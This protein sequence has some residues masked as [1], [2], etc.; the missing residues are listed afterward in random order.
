MKSKL[1][2]LLMVALF[3]LGT[4]TV[5]AQTYASGN[6]LVNPGFEAPAAAGTSTTDNNKIPTGWDTVRVQWFNDFYGVTNI[7]SK[8][9][10][11]RGDGATTKNDSPFFSSVSGASLSGVLTGNFSARFPAGQTAG[12]F[13]KVG[14]TPGAT[15]TFGCNLA[16]YLANNA[17]S[18]KGTEG[19]KI[20]RKD[21][22]LLDSVMIGLD[23]AK[24]LSATD[25]V[26]ATGVF[27]LEKEITIPTTGVDTILFQ[28]ENTNNRPT[29]TGNVPLIC[30][31]ECF[32][33]K[34]QPNPNLL[35]NPGFEDPN[36][37][38]LD[39]P[40]PAP[41]LPVDKDWFVNYYPDETLSQFQDALCASVYSNG[42]AQ[43]FFTTS[44]GLT[45]PDAIIGSYCGR[46]SLTASTG[47]YQVINDVTPGNY[48]I[49]VRIAYTTVNNTQSIP[50]NTVKVLSP[51]GMTTYGKVLI[52]TDNQKKNGQRTYI[53]PFIVT[54]VV[55]IPEGVNRVRFQLDQPYNGTPVTPLLLFDD[56]DFYKLPDF[57]VDAEG[58]TRS[59]SEYT[60]GDYGDI[61]IN[62]NDNSTGQLTIPEGENLTANGVVK[63]EK[64]FTA[65]QWYPIGF[66]FKI[67]SVHSDR[68]N[69]NK[70]LLVTYKWG[71]YGSIGDRGDYYL[72]F[73][74]G[75]GNKDQ[76][77]HYTPGGSP[78]IEKGGYILQVPPALDGA[79]F[80]FTSE[81]N[82]TLSNSNEIDKSSGEYLLAYNPS[83]ANSTVTN[84]PDYF[85]A[86]KGV[87]FERISSSYQL[88]PFESVVVASGI[89][90][91][92]LRSSL[93]IDVVT[94]IPSPDLSNDKPVA[95][96]YYNLLGVKVALPVKGNIYLVKTIFESGKTSVVKQFITYN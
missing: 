63:F 5:K 14:V 41:W 8:Y 79:T 49:S 50:S 95:T 38:T 3:A 10:S 13:Q 89:A 66:P 74:E 94:A 67:D 45:I 15:Y 32:F 85:Y 91:E 55:T 75:D 56:C 4:M 51:D 88:K 92:A 19:V 37:G 60:S 64:A 27:N 59:A 80:T 48:A 31:D 84:S 76:F 62:S 61:I 73:Y 6:L 57:V 86:F 23:Q 83:V 22:T 11:Y 87:N 72:K 52:P 96:E 24:K 20:L 33:R 16:I 58:P 35:V 69:F 68:E 7:A 34:L 12:V 78:T 53:S 21:G 44:N 54:G 17:Q 25:P 30:Y 81:P 77:S 70:D 46:V 9:S 90:P 43:T 40:L 39:S 18:I 65:G 71:D 1:L 36:P 93:N 42:S 2:Q 26:F 47:I 29:A 28:L 82:I